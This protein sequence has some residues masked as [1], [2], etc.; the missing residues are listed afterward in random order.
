[1]LLRANRL[2]IGGVLCRFNSM[3]LLRA[4]M[5]LMVLRLS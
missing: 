4:G 1:L 3:M 5:G 2:L